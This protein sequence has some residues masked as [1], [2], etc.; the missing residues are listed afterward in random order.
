MR[1][2]GAAVQL[3]RT[4]VA[5]ALYESRS[6]GPGLG[7][8]PSPRRRR[9]WLF[10]LLKPRGKTPTRRNPTVLEPE[11]LQ[12]NT[13]SGADDGRET[14]S[15]RSYAVIVHPPLA[16]VMYTKGILDDQF[17]SQRKASEQHTGAKTIRARRTIP[18]Y[19]STSRNKRTRTGAN[20]CRSNSAR[21]NKLV[22]AKG[23]GPG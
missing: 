4:P 2:V 3:Q 20:R 23:R 21:D 1:P 14:F 16:G 18:P 7:F 13:R 10:T 5:V 9:P 17:G 19:R 8:T 6:R 11:H 15:T 12:D 22:I